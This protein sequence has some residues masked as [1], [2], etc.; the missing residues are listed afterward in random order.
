MDFYQRS[1]KG[2]S[3]DDDEEMDWL[4]EM[5]E[6]ILEILFTGL[7]LGP[8]AIADNIDRSREGVSNRLNTLQAGGLVRKVDRGKYELTD[9]GK[10]YVWQDAGLSDAERIGSML[11][12]KQI[13]EEIRELF[14]VSPDEYQKL[15]EEEHE[16][17]R[18]EEP[19]CEH[20][21]IEARERVE[22]QLREEHSYFEHAKEELK[23][24]SEAVEHLD[25]DE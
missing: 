16:R 10:T 1:S 11:T 23:G 5:D 15:V 7:V 3:M 22:K 17:I 24:E 4:T 12:V 8:T 21:F 18:N 14:G 19:E 20:P 6:E 2:V 25:I 13:E 9:Q